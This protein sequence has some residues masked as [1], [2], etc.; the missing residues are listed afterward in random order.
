M[1]LTIPVIGIPK[2]QPRARAFVRRGCKHAGVYDPGTADDWKSC[3]YL[4]ARQ[5]LLSAGFAGWPAGVPLMLS[6]TYR[7]PRPKRLGKRTM[8][9]HTGKPDLDNLIKATKDAL[10]QAGV[11]HDDSQVAC[12]RFAFKHYADRDDSTGASIAIEE[13]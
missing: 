6:V 13:V 2:G 9:P 11:W 3:V 1:N 5:A 10:S 7:L 4:A 12:Y 8:V